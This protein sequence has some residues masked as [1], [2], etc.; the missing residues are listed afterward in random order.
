MKE[1]CLSDEGRQRSHVGKIGTGLLGEPLASY[2][3]L[4]V[5]FGLPSWVIIWCPRKCNSTLLSHQCSA[6]IRIAR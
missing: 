1:I 6:V 3:G 4:H 2:L 5:P